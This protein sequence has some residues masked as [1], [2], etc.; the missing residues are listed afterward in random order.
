MPK[1][2]CR[3][4]LHCRKANSSL[5]VCVVVR[6]RVWA[7]VRARPCARVCACG[8]SRWN[9]WPPRSCTGRRGR[10]TEARVRTVGGGSPWVRKATGER[11]WPQPLP[12]TSVK[13]RSLQNGEWGSAA[14]AGWDCVRLVQL[15][16]QPPLP[17]HRLPSRRR[18][19]CTTTMIVAQTY[20]P[21]TKP[22]SVRWDLASEP[23]ADGAVGVPE[24]RDVEGEARRA[25]AATFAQVCESKH[26]MAQVSCRPNVHV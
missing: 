13:R 4:F 9:T 15:T 24:E 3:C 26:I 7:R 1:P 21:M 19:R 25:A 22:Q 20:P 16:P 8:C 17:P 18:V 5:W 11:A 14:T 23:S 2:V 10:W 12:R 6:R